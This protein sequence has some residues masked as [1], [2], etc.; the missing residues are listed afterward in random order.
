[1]ISI[2]DERRNVH[3][4]CLFG[5]VEKGAEVDGIQ[6]CTHIKEWTRKRDWE[7][8]RVW[9]I[10]VLW[11]TRQGG[12]L[13]LVR[14][15]RADGG[16]KGIRE[17]LLS[18]NRKILLRALYQRHFIQPP[19]RSL[20]KALGAQPMT[21]MVTHHRARPLLKGQRGPFISEF[22]FPTLVLLFSFSLPRSLSLRLSSNPRLRVFLCQPL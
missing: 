20:K 21:W 11:F 9:G 15:L 5:A 10:R 7:R 19:P 13:R 1:M 8:G 4:R 17:A 3:T 16:A 22:P 6:Q 12:K 14:G 2:L 18:R